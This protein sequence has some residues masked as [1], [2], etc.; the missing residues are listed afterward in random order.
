MVAGIT[1]AGLA[2]AGKFLGGAASAG[3]LLSSLFGGSANAPDVQFKRPAMLEQATKAGLIFGPGNEFNLGLKDASASGFSSR[4]SSF[5]PGS[6]SLPNNFKFQGS[7]STPQG[8]GSF[9]IDP[10]QAE[11]NIQKNFLPRLSPEAVAAAGGDDKNLQ[12]PG[13]AVSEDIL[14]GNKGKRPKFGQILK[15]GID[16][17]L[18]PFEQMM[19][20]Q[21]VGREAFETGILRGFE[22]VGEGRDIITSLRDL[23]GQSNEE[24]KA[25]AQEL[26]D[27]TLNELRN[28]QG[29]FDA[30]L[31]PVNSLFGEAAQGF[32]DINTDTDLGT[33]RALIGQGAQIAGRSAD[34]GFQNAGIGRDITSQALGDK[35]FFKTLLSQRFG[36]TDSFLNSLFSG[37][38]PIEQALI[39]QVADDNIALG[40]RSLVTGPVGREFEDRIR[41]ARESAAG[42]GFT[43]LGSASID[44]QRRVEQDRRDQELDIVLSELARRSQ[45]TLTASQQAREARLAAADIAGRGAN[46]LAGVIPQ[47]LSAASQGLNASTAGVSAATDAGGLLS[48]LAGRST[49][50][51]RLALDT[52]KA[53][54]GG[55][56]D[57]ATRQGSVATQAAGVRTSDSRLGQ[58]GLDAAIG[59]ELG[60]DS[61]T[62]NALATAGSQNTNLINAINAL[63]QTG[64]AGQ[65]QGFNELLSIFDIARGQRLNKQRLDIVNAFGDIGVPVSV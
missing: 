20:L 4:P 48:S 14:L 15:A 6:V 40:Q 10:N 1:A 23:A 42:K 7:P 33:T 31:A 50:A 27:F 22:G 53:R 21:G 58:E 56:A 61:Q 30:D 43:S 17:G 36:Q 60:V 65:E 44:A 18:T 62:L 54:A 38:D 49:D 9:V 35:D 5:N 11:G 12:I 25:R 3:G 2:G 28:R 8:F 64:L 47:T 29:R 63:S 45:N 37:V 55:L 51:G 52:Q 32:R 57:T 16:A 59:R 34:E 46:T 19:A 39:N 26:R 24:T 41:E 13:S